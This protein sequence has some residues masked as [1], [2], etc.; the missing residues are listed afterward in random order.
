MSVF[1]NLL[2]LFKWEPEKDG[3]E[4]FDIDKALNENWDK[5]DNKID[6]IMNQSDDIDENDKY[7]EIFELIGTKRGAIISGGRVDYEKVSGI[8]LDEFRSGKLGKITLEKVK[9]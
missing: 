2:N 7:L 9:I 5:L 8:L 4:E 3:E 6:E 1:T